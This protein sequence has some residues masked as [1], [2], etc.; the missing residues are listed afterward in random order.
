MSVQIEVSRGEL[1]DK[2]TILK[3]THERI[4]DPQRL[5]ILARVHGGPEMWPKPVDTE[6]AAI[7]VE[8]A[9]ASAGR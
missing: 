6:L 5:A 9:T 1:R 3:I 8:V 4:A 7:D 2:M